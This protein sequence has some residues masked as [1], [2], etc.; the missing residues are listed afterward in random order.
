MLAS[1]ARTD[2]ATGTV[3]MYE[4]HLKAINP[5]LVTI[6]YE[7][8]DLFRFMDSLG[9]ICCLEFAPAQGMFAPRDRE[10]MKKAIFAQFQQ[11]SGGGRQGGGR[12]R[13]GRSG[14][15]GGGRQGGGRGR[16]GRGGG[17]RR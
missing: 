16:G 15:G 2:R 17:R 5:G 8:T 9:D 3:S 1:F 13:G 12:S 7:I 10:W 14:R 4:A 11:Q 6:Q